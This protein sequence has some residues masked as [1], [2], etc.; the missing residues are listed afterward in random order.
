MPWALQSQPSSLR[1][2]KT[3]RTEAV[4]GPGVGLSD[5]TSGHPKQSSTGIRSF[6]QS[7]LLI[8]PVPGQHFEA[9]YFLCFR[10]AI[11]KVTSFQK[12][13]NSI[14]I[15]SFEQ[16][17][18]V[19]R[20]VLGKPFEARYLHR[21][22]IAVDLLAKLKKQQNRTGIRSLRQSIESPWEPIVTCAYRRQA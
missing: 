19:I 9:R 7:Y 13:Q 17:Y 12:Q 11:T 10:V 6:G 16:S 5:I 4:Y 3:I 21:L 15:V 8:G 1:A 20:V 22:A 2:L 18:L 14:G